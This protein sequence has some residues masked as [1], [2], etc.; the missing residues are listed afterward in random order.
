MKN[1]YIRRARFR[2][3]ENRMRELGRQISGNYLSLKK[4]KKEKWTELPKA[5]GHHQTYQQMHNWSPLRRGE[6]WEK[7]AERIFEEIMP[8]NSQNLTETWTWTSK[9]FNELQ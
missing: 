3:D 7:G 9:K 2:L 1:K 8:P 4:N 5:V 6:E